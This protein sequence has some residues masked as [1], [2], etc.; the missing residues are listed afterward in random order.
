MALNGNY[1]KY[2]C[3]LRQKKK[4]K[5]ELKNVSQQQNIY[6]QKK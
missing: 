6:V 1:I 5:W 2:Y 3:Y 4:F